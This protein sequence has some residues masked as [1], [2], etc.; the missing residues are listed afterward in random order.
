MT[1]A[2][3]LLVALCAR[4]LPV[5][6]RAEWA[7][8][9]EGEIAEARTVASG[10]GWW[11]EARL[12]PGVVA[13]AFATRRLSWAIT[14]VRNEPRPDWEGLTG[15]RI[16]GWWTD[17]RHAARGLWAR[18]G[19]AVSATLTLA[20]GIGATTAVFSAVNSVLLRELPYSDSERIVVVQQRDNRD[21]ALSAGASAANVHDLSDR[22]QT[23]SSVGMADGIHGLRL[24]RDGRAE[25]LRAWVV[26]DGFFA[27]LDARPMLGRLFDPAEYVLGGERVVIL[28]QGVWQ[29]RFGADPG[30]LGRELVLDD[31]AHRVVGVLPDEFQYPSPV[32]AWAPRARD[33]SD[34]QFR[35]WAGMRTVLRLRPGVEVSEAQSEADQIARTLAATYP[36]TNANTG[37]QLTPLRDNLL[38]DVESPLRLLMAAVMLVLLIALANVA[39]L[40]VARG[41]SRARENAVRGALGATSRRVARMAFAE[42][43]LLA[44]AGG[45]LGVAIAYLGVAVI[46]MIG[47]NHLPRI[48]DLRIDGVVLGFALLVSICSALAAAVTPA[49]RGSRVDLRAVLSESS[50]GS[51]AGVGAAAF[52]DKLVVGEIAIALMLTVGAGLLLRSFD[53]LLD[54]ELG[55]DPSGLVATQVFA[56]NDQHEGDFAYFD[57]GAAALRDLPG[58]E[59]VGVTSNLPLSD[60]ESVLARPIVVS[61]DIADRPPPSGASEPVASLSV[62]DPAYPETMRIGLV[63]G[64]RFTV[65]DDDQSPPVALINEAFARRY[66][67]DRDPLGERVT[68]RF[69][70]GRT[71]EVVGVLRDVRRQGLESDADPEVYLPLAQAPFNGLTFVVRARTEASAMVGTI[72]ETL[73]EADPSQAIWAN[74]TIA[75]MLADW[76]RERVF[77]TVLVTAFAALALTLAAIGVYGLMAFSVGERTGEFGIRR[78]LGGEARTILATVLLKGVRLAF[79]GVALGVVG[80]LGMTQL[81]QG[82][83]FGVQR[84]DPMTF[85]GVAVVVIGIAT[86]ATLVPAHRATRVDPLVA[87]SGSRR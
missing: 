43:L 4:L 20:L 36:Q 2:A 1:P 22:L 7:A 40:Q 52:R 70:E 35:G 69:R 25:S 9:W 23:A 66:F 67:S 37:F 16:E 19:F 48:G 21:G 41:A 73:L 6:M 58:V 86:V 60:T 65:G 10:L 87:L 26:S 42:S 54:N 59:S 32:D 71:W 78:A 34:E 33:Q 79:A 39:G 61:F 12:L 15:M 55:F 84:F 8:E 77:I 56:Y 85:V 63:A 24:V 49:L 28:S 57:R 80:A 83:L 29:N 13:D 53:T 44:T 3:G 74:R 5:A 81:L 30:I 76:M 62:I 11:T 82:M 72:R 64:R 75:E 38:G 45:G 17:M 47:P 18:P 27:A 14:Q 50:R 31:V 46:Q 51:T 68:L